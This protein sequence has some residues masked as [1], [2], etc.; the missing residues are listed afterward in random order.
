MCSLSVSLSV[1]VIMA[2]WLNAHLQAGCPTGDRFFSVESCSEA[3]G[4]GFRIPDGVSYS[5]L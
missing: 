4:G 1:I 2:F 5:H 3:V